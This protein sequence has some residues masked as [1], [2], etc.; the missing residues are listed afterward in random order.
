MS[1]HEDYVGLRQMLDHACE[2]TAML[3]DHT[4]EDLEE[5]RMLELALVHLVEIVGEAANRVSDQTCERFPSIPWSA[6]VGMRNRLAHGYDK[7]DLQILYDTIIEDL[8]PLIQTLEDVLAQM[9]KRDENDKESGA[10][11]PK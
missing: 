4:R 2:A 6:I 3:G 11:P 7:V 10:I 8:P 9:Q 1:R 5:N